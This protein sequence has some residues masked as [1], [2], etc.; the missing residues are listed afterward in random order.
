MIKN[1]KI[2]DNI[3]KK[4]EE[5]NEIKV[6]DRFLDNI[7][8]QTTEEFKEDWQNGY[9]TDPKS[10]SRKKLE[11]LKDSTIKSR[12]YKKA[13][14]RLSNKTTPETSNLIDS[15]YTI[16]ETKYKISDNKFEIIP[17]DDMQEALSANEKLKRP[18]FYLRN[19]LLKKIQKE[20]LKEILK[21]TKFK[22]DKM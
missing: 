11:E 14:G 21:L 8:K 3:T 1:N 16:A 13:K 18:L 4:L 15:G 22:I 12:T 19:D 5:L 2:F 6:S 20:F 10:K 17:P 9:G 7:A